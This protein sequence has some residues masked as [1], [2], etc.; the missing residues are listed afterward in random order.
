MNLWNTLSKFQ[1]RT[2]QL[3]QV[4][5]DR[6]LQKSTGQLSLKKSELNVASQCWWQNG[7]ICAMVSKFVVSST[8]VVSMNS[9]ICGQ[10]QVDFSPSHNKLKR[11]FDINV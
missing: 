4:T 2:I 5:Q 9:V 3:H 8:V 1:F 11:N 6:K 10:F 7:K